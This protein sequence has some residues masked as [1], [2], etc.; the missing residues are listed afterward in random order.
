[1]IPERLETDREGMISWK[2]GQWWYS[3]CPVAPH[4]VGQSTGENAAA[5]KVLAVLSSPIFSA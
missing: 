2:R 4:K 1:V 3:A 5:E